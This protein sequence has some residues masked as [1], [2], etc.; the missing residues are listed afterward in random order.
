MAEHFRR[1]RILREVFV[2]LAAGRARALIHERLNVLREST[3]RAGD[4][5]ITVEL[6]ERDL[7]WLEKLGGEGLR[8]LDSQAEPRL[9]QSGSSP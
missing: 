2:P 6:E 4:W 9:A 8:V 1:N 7:G 3:D 5:S